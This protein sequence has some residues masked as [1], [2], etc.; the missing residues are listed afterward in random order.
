[1]RSRYLALVS[2]IA[3]TLALLAAGAPAQE[4]KG[5]SYTKIPTVKGIDTLKAG[6]PAPDFVVKDIRGNVDTRLQKLADGQYDA[7]EKVVQAASDDGLVITSG[8][9][10]DM[11]LASFE[12]KCTS[13]VVLTNNNLP[14]P[15]LLA[16]ADEKKIPVLLLHPGHPAACPGPGITDLHPDHQFF[17]VHS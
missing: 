3:V 14:P 7:S 8:D 9:R 2:T 10:S 16:K 11:L 15:N 17:G 1:M 5:G 12:D 4:S 13:A 6:A